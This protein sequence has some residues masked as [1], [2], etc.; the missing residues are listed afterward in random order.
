MLMIAETLGIR[1]EREAV[2]IYRLIEHEPERQAAK[3]KAHRREQW[4]REKDA[5]LQNPAQ[6]KA[7]MEL[8][9]KEKYLHELQQRLTESERDVKNIDSLTS[10]LNASFVPTVTP[11]KSDWA[12][13]G[14]FVEGA[15]GSTAAGL[16]TA[17]EIQRENARAEREAAEYNANALQ[18]HQKLMRDIAGVRNTV[19]QKNQ[20]TI[21]SLSHSIGLIEGKLVNE[22]HTGELWERLTVTPQLIAKSPYGNP[23][24]VA[25]CSVTVDG[26]IE[27]LGSPAS[28]DGSLHVIIK[29]AQGK[30][31]AEGY[32]CPPGFGVADL[33]KV[34]FAMEK[35]FDAV[36]EPLG[37]MP[38]DVTNLTCEVTPHDLWAIEQ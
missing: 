1:D 27:V 25:R 17:M 9:G 5:E 19:A 6:Q 20:P 38:T 16:A 10:A 36:C 8:R 2:R 3:R 22:G 12:A 24:I 18:Q 35:T 28:L 32:H 33:R 4:R 14:G 23:L 21:D 30:V 29:D 37:E 26:P 13:W 11:Q 15:T 31:I 34:G 7:L